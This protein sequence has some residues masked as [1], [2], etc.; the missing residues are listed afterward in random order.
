MNHAKLAILASTSLCLGLS[1]S[2]AADMALKA[3]RAPVVTDPWV[4]FYAGGNIGYSWGRTDTSI[5]VLP[6]GLD[7]LAN[8]GTFVFPGAASSASSNVNGVIGGGQFGFVGRIAPHWLGGV[9]AD[10]Q[11]SGQRGSVRGQVA[12]LAPDCT[13]NDCSFTNS[14][15][16]TTRLNWFG[17]FR[18]RAG[19]EFDKFW[20]Y[21]TA[22]F[23]YGNVSVSGSNNLLLINNNGPAVIGNF[24]TPYSYSQLKG[25][26]TAGLGIEGLI[27]DGRWRWKLEYLHIDLGSI[28]GGMFGG[29]PTVA[30]EYDQIYR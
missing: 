1:A 21:G 8:F 11:W 16:I 28:N 18:G 22:G 15:D 17:T 19:V 12:G 25:G 14:H 5:S 10:I 29:F 26:W 30:G 23:A 7:N 2:N 27:G 13:S 4:G 6:F 20:I 3:P 9:E 24:V